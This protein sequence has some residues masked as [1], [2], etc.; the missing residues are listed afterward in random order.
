MSGP[1]RRASRRASRAS[2]PGVGR[3]VFPDVGG[4]E[5]PEVAGG[6]RGLR[7]QEAAAGGDDEHAGA[8]RRRV[9]EG[10]GIGHLAPEIEAAQEGEQ[11][12]EGQALIA[13]A[14]GDVGTGSRTEGHLFRPGPPAV[15][16]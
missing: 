13:E 2:G 11:F 8:G 16:G 3:D 9:G 5:D 1:A 4:G 6:D 12:P 10:A 7:S 14:A 15:G